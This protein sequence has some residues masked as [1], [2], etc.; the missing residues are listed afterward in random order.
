M[1][2]SGREKAKPN[3]YIRIQGHIVERLAALSEGIFAVAMTLLAL[4]RWHGFRSLT[5][6]EMEDKV[7]WLLIG[8]ALAAVVIWAISRRRR[9]WL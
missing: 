4:V 7:I 8:A 3:L 5:E 1:I 2:L 6:G 9:R